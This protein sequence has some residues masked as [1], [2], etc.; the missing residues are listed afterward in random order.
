MELLYSLPSY[1]N[2]NILQTVT[3]LTTRMSAL[4]QFIF[5]QCT[6]FIQPPPTPDYYPLIVTVVPFV[7]TND[8]A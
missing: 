1:R 3:V 5:T 7:T 6:H 8:Q 2:G 4:I